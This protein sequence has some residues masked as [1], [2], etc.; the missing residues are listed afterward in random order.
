M[1]G[2]IFTDHKKALM[3]GGA[4]LLGVVVLVGEEDDEGALTKVAAVSQN[5]GS[6]RAQPEAGY[7][8]REMVEDDGE[9]D[10]RGGADYGGDDDSDFDFDDEPMDDAEGFDASPSDETTSSADFG[11]TSASSTRVQPS[12]PEGLEL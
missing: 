1:A 11:E 5:D 9:D 12:A 7:G 4:I 8:I 2:N 10:S 3:F 6:F